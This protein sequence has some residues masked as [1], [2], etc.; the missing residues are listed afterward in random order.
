V[1][2]VGLVRL[3][4]VRREP[5]E[6]ATEFGD[7]GTY[8]RID[9][10]AHYAVDPAVTANAEI[11]DLGHA[12]RDG[13]DRVCFSG[14]VVVLRPAV[15]SRGNRVALIDIPNRG[16]RVMTGL[17]N[18]AV[19]DVPQQRR[20]PAGDGFLMRHGFTLAWCGWQWDVPRG[21]DRMGLDAPLVLGDDGKPAT[22]WMQLRVQLPDDAASVP[23][24]DQHVGSIGNHAPIPTVDADD[25]EAKLYVR[26]GL[27][28]AP[29]LV[30][31][32][33]WRFALASNGEV[34][35]DPRHLWVEGGIRA[36]RIYDL[37][38]RAASCP[39][40]GT[41]LL[42]V[43]DLAAFVRSD[44]SDN[45]LNGSVDRVLLT[46]VSQTS[47]FIRNLLYLGLDVDEH[48]ARA[49]DGALGLVGGARRGEFNHRGA[50]PSVQPT[51][52]F[53]HRFPF[54][55]VAQVDPRTGRRDGLLERIAAAGEPPKLI[56]VDT[57]AEYWRGD[58]SL[59]HTNVA[60]G[61]DVDRA[62]FVRHYLY[63][64]AQH[65]SGFAELNDRSVSGAHGANPLNMVD[66]T[67]LYRCALVNLVRW[68]CDGVS[69]PP[70]AVPRWSDH[71]A[72][73]RDDAL[74]QLSAI[75]SLALPDPAELPV[76]SALDLGPDADRGIGRYPADPIGA[77]YPCAVSAL[78]A[79]G[80]ETAGVR[81][82]DVS[83]PVATHLGF[84]PRHAD[85]GGAG[86][87]ID[88]FGSSVPFARTAAERERLGDPRPSLE[89]RYANIS[90]YETAV[91]V[92]A[93]QLVD[94]HQLLP[95]DVELCVRL[96]HRRYLVVSEQPAAVGSGIE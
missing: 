87:I 77:P 12:A 45:P 38:Y 71:S 85:S 33:R 78:D 67:P 89:E 35:S 74:K 86:Q 91:R 6:D 68:V 56:F 39:V 31:R 72:V 60:D 21:D 73:H 14:D 70:S 40:A 20:V 82:P 5:Y 95:E 61:S 47:R 17:F 46:G 79:D 84:N 24:T 19:L 65:S 62:P 7:V 32:D 16:R 96:A 93:Q 51:P 52:S 42:A 22:A 94:E 3:E 43:R 34:R 9:A 26:D 29:S 64:A 23:L 57:A 1:R 81:M 69:P 76:L 8:E 63:A 48:G 2:N 4:I 88:Y 28:S 18:R 27:H 58:A 50:Q 92:A 80:N 25:A 83:V 10:I 13:E 55:D 54:A 53:G 37:V 75:P 41:G 30:A 90:A 11:V 66:Y 59:A 44:R 49:V 15:P 36:G